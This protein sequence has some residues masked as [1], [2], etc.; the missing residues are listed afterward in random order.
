MPLTEALLLPVAG[1]H[2]A[3]E[4]SAV[5]L[6]VPS[7]RG[8]TVICTLTADPALI[9]PRL[10]FTAR[11]KGSNEQLPCEAVAAVNVSCMGRVSLSVTVGAAAWPGFVITGF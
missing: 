10:Q 4:M 6:S 1:S 3:A 8:L 11:S 7:E 2:C 9:V 5:S